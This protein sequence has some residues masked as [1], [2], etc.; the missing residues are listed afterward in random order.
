MGDLYGL[1]REQDPAARPALEASI[2][3]GLAVVEAVYRVNAAA[4]RSQGPFLLGNK[5]SMAEILI[6]PFLYRFEATLG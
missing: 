3:E 2:R 5:L 6:M 4:Y 1:L